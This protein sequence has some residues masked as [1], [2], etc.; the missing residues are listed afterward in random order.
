LIRSK[1]K[2]HNKV[3]IVNPTPQTF[4]AL[5]KLDLPS[6]VDI[7]MPITTELYRVLYEDKNAREAVLDLM[8]R[9][10]KHEMDEYASKMINWL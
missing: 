5:M 3:D 1:V 9:R 10:K 6:G 7:E 8:T 2:F 4:D